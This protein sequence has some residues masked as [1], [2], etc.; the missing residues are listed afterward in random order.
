[1]ILTSPVST[2][3]LKCANNNKWWG[4]P[5]MFVKSSLLML[6][7]QYSKR[8][9]KIIKALKYFQY[10]KQLEP[11]ELYLDKGNGEWG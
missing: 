1:M 4:K 11:L 8:A 7:R 6:A 9:T 5:K 3:H 2:K 10:G